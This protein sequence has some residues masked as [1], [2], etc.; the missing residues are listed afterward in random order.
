MARTI[1]LRAVPDPILRSLRDRARRNRRS[2]QKEIL[3]ILEQAAVDRA[4]M[5]EQIALVRRRLG[6]KMS[7]E[8]IHR[9]IEE[10]RV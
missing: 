9:A 3:S 8:Q 6:A 7:L 1:T 5:A 10:G 2:M 4:S